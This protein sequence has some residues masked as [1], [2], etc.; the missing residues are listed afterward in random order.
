MFS[1]VVRLLASTAAAALI[2]STATLSHAQLYEAV[3]EGSGPQERVRYF[4]LNPS[5]GD[6]IIAAPEVEAVAAAM[7]AAQAMDR[8]A[9]ILS[10]GLTSIGDASG[11]FSAV[12]TLAEQVLLVPGL[13]NINTSLN[14]LGLVV[15]G[16][17]V[18]NDLARGDDTS[19]A[20]GAYKGV[21]GYVIS[22]YGWGAL[23]VAGVSIYLFDMTLREWNVAVN[24]AA[25]ANW[26]AAYQE[27]YRT[28]GRSVN[29]WKE[30]VWRLYLRAELRNG[31]DRD[32]ARNAFAAYVDGEINAFVNRAFAEEVGA[33]HDGG[34][35]LF[36][37]FGFGHRSVAERMV[38]EAKTAL[39]AMIARD[40]LPEIAERAQARE[41]LKQLDQMNWYLR[42]EMNRLIRLDVTFWGTEGAEHVSIPVEGGDWGGPLA[43]DGTFTLDFTRYAWLKAGVPQRVVVSTGAGPVEAPIRILGDRAIAVF[44]VPP[45]ASMVRYDLS[46]GARS[47]QERLLDPAT[48]H[49]VRIL[50]EYDLPA[51]PDSTLDIAV[52]QSGQTIVGQF[53]TETVE[54]RDA[55]P[56]HYDPEDGIMRFGP[57]RVGH[58]A[59]IR[60]CRFGSISSGGLVSVEGCVFVRRTDMTGGADLRERYC[61]NPGRMTLAGAWIDLGECYAS[62]CDMLDRG[63]AQGDGRMRPGAMGEEGGARPRRADRRRALRGDTCP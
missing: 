13:E 11:G 7:E 44:G 1:G 37:S 2:I 28:K 63:D 46:E 40:V 58:L 34:G 16:L 14:Y 18:A 4:Q 21:F 42:P 62:R 45:S 52:L 29:D 43:T 61:R 35:G 8:S 23:Q 27:F 31:D 17:Q 22:Q 25:D 57:P 60:E 38:G 19:A 9:T 54:W 5:A 6:V 36:S 59:E 33:Y 55:S 15:V 56:G 47:C 49:A 48:R 30:T 24:A 12:G 41:E 32:A 53:D 26:R 50:D 20:A 51:L 39:E 10:A 3:T